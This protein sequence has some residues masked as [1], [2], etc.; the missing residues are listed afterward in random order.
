MGESSISKGEEKMTTEEKEVLRD[1][2][3]EMELF[4]GD[5]AT[6]ECHHGEGEPCG[7]DATWRVVLLCTEPECPRAA[8]SMLLCAPCKT[9]WERES[10]DIPLTFERI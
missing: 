10:A 7:E 5:N 3:M 1:E 6:C 8:E 2:I 4:L 9:T